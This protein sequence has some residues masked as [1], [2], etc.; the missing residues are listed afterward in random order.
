VPKEPGMRPQLTVRCA[1]E[2]T[3][4]VRTDFPPAP[5]SGGRLSARFTVPA[6]CRYQWISLWVRGSFDRRP[7]EIAWVTDVRIQSAGKS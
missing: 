6:N 4:L 5:A 2:N 3:E 7:D 1:T